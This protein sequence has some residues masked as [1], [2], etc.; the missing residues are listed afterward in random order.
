[1]RRYKF[2]RKVEDRKREDTSLVEDRRS[3]RKVFQLE[4]ST[5]TKGGN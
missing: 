3:S 2:S 5:G 4:D 1:M